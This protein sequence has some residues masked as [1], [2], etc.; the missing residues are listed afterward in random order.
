[1]CYSSV[2]WN[3]FNRSLGKHLFLSSYKTAILRCTCSNKAALSVSI[4]CPCLSLFLDSQFEGLNRFQFFE[5]REWVLQHLVVHCQYFC[6]FCI[7]LIYCFHFLFSKHLSFLPIR[8]INP[9]FL[10]LSFL[11]TPLFPTNKSNQSIVPLQIEV[12]KEH[13]RHPPTLH[14]LNHQ[15]TS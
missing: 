12:C 8:A 14:D 10:S 2:G 5:H 15:Q 1:M 4:S 6:L 7:M 9:S 11:Q 13:L 3:H